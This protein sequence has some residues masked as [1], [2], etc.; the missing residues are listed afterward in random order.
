MA[1]K[2][3]GVERK[4]SKCSIRTEINT[5]MIEI[6]STVEN[7][8]KLPYRKKVIGPDFYLTPESMCCVSFKKCESALYVYISNKTTAEIKIVR[9]LV[10][11]DCNNK[12]LHEDRD[13]NIFSLVKGTDVDLIEKVENRSRFDTLTKDKLVIYLCV[14]IEEIIGGKIK[15]FTNDTDPEKKLKEDLKTMLENPI[16]SDVSLQVGNERIPVHW[17]VLCS[18]S[19][20]FKRMF[21]SEMKERVQN[22]VII[23]D[24]SI[25]TLKNLIEFL[26]TAN[27]C[28]SDQRGG[29]EELF[30][31][32][33]GAEK[34]EVMDLRTL[35][36]CKIMKNASVDNVLQILQLSHLHNDKDLKMKVMSFIRLHS[37][38]VLQTD[39]WKR[40]EASEPLAADAFSFFLKEN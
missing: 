5:K 39:G 21:E 2:D 37:K 35:C 29:L 36:A 40:F 28:E 27:F 20:Y 10:L 12:K 32:Y 4:I 19:P 7:V 30:E 6:R 8:S 31:I 13:E 18:R 24:I 16:N 23:T 38:A 9:T 33:Y 14:N 22:S 15:C 17:S 34:Y 26:Y 1:Q 11:Y 25:A 3:E